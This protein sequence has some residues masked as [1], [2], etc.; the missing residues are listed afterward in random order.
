MSYIQTDVNVCCTQA[1]ELA[2]YSQM[3]AKRGY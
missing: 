3:N 2:R 1:T